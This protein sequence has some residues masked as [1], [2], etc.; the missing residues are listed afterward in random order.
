MAGS[1]VH[2]LFPSMVAHG[3]KAIGA[4]NA[5]ATDVTTAAG[6]RPGTTA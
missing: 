5:A 2:G 4:G 3:G 1:V 6:D